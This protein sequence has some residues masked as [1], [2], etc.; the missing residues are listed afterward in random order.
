MTEEVKMQR[1]ATNE[2]WERLTEAFAPGVYV[3][4]NDEMETAFTREEIA[5]A[6]LRALGLTDLDA[7]AA[8]FDALLHPNFPRTGRAAEVRR[9]AYLQALE[10]ALTATAEDEPNLLMDEFLASSPTEGGEDG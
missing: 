5:H 10:A 6:A 2:V 4:E 9:E 3:F 1:M 8:R 7:F